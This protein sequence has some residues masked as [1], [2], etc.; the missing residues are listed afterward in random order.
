LARG[1]S[2]ENGTGGGERGGSKPKI[3]KRA[4][5]PRHLKKLETKG[6]I[7][8]MKGIAKKKK[9]KDE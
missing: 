8:N 1:E 3:L 7:Q 9:E 2:V 4:N 6:G 5:V